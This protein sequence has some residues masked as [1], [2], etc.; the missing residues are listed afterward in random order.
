MILYTI[1]F[2]LFSKK[3]TKIPSSHRNRVSFP[4]TLRQKKFLMFMN[5]FT[6]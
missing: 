2:S 3:K 1:S 4:K 5:D 6:H